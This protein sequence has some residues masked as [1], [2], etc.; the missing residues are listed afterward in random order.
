MAPP[1]SVY[2]GA[3]RR[4][5]RRVPHRTRS[6]GRRPGVPGTPGSRP[7]RSRPAAA[8]L[9]VHGHRDPDLPAEGV[10]QGVL[11]PGAQPALELVA[12]EL[13][14]DRD[15]RGAL[16]HRHRLAGRQP[17][18]LVGRQVVDQVA[19]QPVELGGGSAGRVLRAGSSG[20]SSPSRVMVVHVGPPHSRHHR[21]HQVARV[22]WCSAGPIDRTDAAHGSTPLSTGCACRPRVAA[23]APAT[24]RTP[25]VDLRN[26]R[27]TVVRRPW[28]RRRANDLVRWEST[29]GRSGRPNANP[30]RTDRIKRLSTG[31]GFDPCVARRVP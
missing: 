18:A 28:G 12:G 4:R 26:R 6:V 14:G 27:S 19:P 16:V 8:E 30:A 5:P 21:S 20:R 17:G 11:Q 7:D 2:C 23:A 3:G 22:V 13:V 9:G 25:R 24:G 15:D 10:A 29:G 1:Y 31:S